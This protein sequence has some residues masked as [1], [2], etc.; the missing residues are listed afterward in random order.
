MSLFPNKE[1]SEREHKGGNRPDGFRIGLILG[2]L[3]YFLFVS[4]QD[5]DFFRGIFTFD[6]PSVDQSEQSSADYSPEELCRVYHVVDGDTIVV[7]S[8]GAPV[9]VRLIGVDTPE[10]VKPKTPPQ[11]Y[12]P[13]ATNYTT[14][15]ISAFNDQVVL[16]RDG[17]PIDR[18]GRRLAMVYLGEDGTELLNEELIRHGLGKAELQY[19]YSDTM[20]LRFQKAE[21]E[22]KADRLGIW[23]LPTINDGGTKK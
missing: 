22:A 11:P 3:L 2:I 10:A 12:G 5:P 4:S 9:R 7:I 15:R 6:K 18:Y 13:E 23:S 8:E 14:N 21:N 20:K 17:D 1:N 19:N 16:R